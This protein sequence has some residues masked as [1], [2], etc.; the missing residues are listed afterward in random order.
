MNSSLPAAMAGCSGVCA[1]RGS[2]A[3]FYRQGEGRRNK[4]GSWRCLMGRKGRLGGGDARQ[5]LGR[6][7]VLVARDWGQSATWPVRT[8]YGRIRGSSDR[9]RWGQVVPAARWRHGHATGR[10]GAEQERDFIQ[11]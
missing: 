6:P 9:A 1:G 11:E 7:A 3:P 2:A 10:Q 5:R 8:G 4:L